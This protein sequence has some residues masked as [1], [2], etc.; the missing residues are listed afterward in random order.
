VNSPQFYR[1]HDGPDSSKAAIACTRDE[2]KLW[3]TPERGWGVFFTVNQFNGPRRKE[4]LARINAWAVDMDE[5]DKLKQHAIISRSPLVPS[6]I[7]ET[8]RGF[9][10]YWEAQD[11]AKPEHWNAI[12]LERLVP[13]FGADK[14]ARDLCRILRVPGSLHLK[15]PSAPFKCQLRWKH[16]VQYSERQM[17][18]AFRWVP[19]K[20]VVAEMR[21]ESRKST[22]FDSG[23]SFWEA[24]GNLN[25]EEGLSRLSGHWAVSG[26]QYTFRRNANGKTNLFVDGKGTSVF[27][28]EAGKIGSLSGGGPT[29]AQWLLWFKHDYKVVIAVLKELYPQLEEIDRA[30]RAKWAAEQAEI[31]RRAA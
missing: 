5:G 21:A 18:D 24:V 22:G 19:S 1:M 7:V 25:C 27:I 17:A 2:A 14:N 15:D 30:G 31:R 6:M 16:T 4:H 9:Q 28:D 12:V 20:T 23:E 13:F 10:V 8:K 3:N 26:E 11:G 29:L